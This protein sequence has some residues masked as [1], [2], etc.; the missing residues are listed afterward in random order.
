MRRKTHDTIR[1]VTVDI[2]ERMHLNTAVSSMMELVNELYA[3][4]DATPHG[5]PSRAEPPVGR[6]ERAQT[7][8]VLREAIDALVLMLSP[9]APHTAE[10]LW[11]MLGHPN[12]LKDASW[13][14]YDPEIAKADEVVV[15]VQINGKVRARLTL[16]ASLSDDELRERALADAAV[17]NHTAGKTVRKVVVAKGPLVSVV[18]S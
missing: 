7:I 15:P 8:A 5:A 13:P 12:P 4:S 16:P 9:F 18:V 11:Q 17:K 6:V 3:F 14:S 2:E 1:R 10:E